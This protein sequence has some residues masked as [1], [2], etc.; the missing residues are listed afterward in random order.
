MRPIDQSV[1]SIEVVAVRNDGKK[2][3]IAEVAA[4]RIV[5]P[6]GF[7]IWRDLLPGVRRFITRRG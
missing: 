3:T 4:D 6:R 5:D 2:A 1:K 7:V